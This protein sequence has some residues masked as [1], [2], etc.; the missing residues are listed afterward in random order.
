MINFLS[1]N[2]N[3]TFLTFKSIFISYPLISLI[4]IRCFVNIHF[5]DRIAF[6]LMVRLNEN[7]RYNN[8]NDLTLRYDNKKQDKKNVSY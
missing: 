6:I 4:K 3:E 7:T 2:Q 8:L 5:Y 1:Y